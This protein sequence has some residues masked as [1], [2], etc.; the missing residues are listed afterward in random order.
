MKYEQPHDARTESAQKRRVSVSRFI[1]P[2]AVSLMPTMS[3]IVDAAVS[4]HS[5]KMIPTKFSDVK[6]FRT[7]LALAPKAP[8]MNSAVF[9]QALPGHQNAFIGL[10]GMR[11]AFFVRP[12]G[13]DSS[14]KGMK[15]EINL[16]MD[17]T[18]PDAAAF[19]KA[20]EALD[21]FVL[22]EVFARKT[23]LMPSKAA[24][25]T[26]VDALKPMYVSGQFLKPATHAQNGT[27]YPPS[28][29]LK[30]VGN[31]D[32][33]VTSVTTRTVTMRGATRSIPDK[34]TW[35]PRTD[36]VGPEETK[37]F[38]Y[39]RTKE[40]GEDVYVEKVPSADGGGRYVGPE[41]ATPGCFISAIFSLNCVYF[42][43]GFGVSAVARAIY[44]KPRPDALPTFRGAV[45][46]ALATL[47]GTSVEDNDDAA[48]T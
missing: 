8:G 16:Q 25:I 18:S 17:E 22:H 44:I 42:S 27:R 2:D 34:C 39:K 7:V 32:K 23:E 6:D 36:A 45:S 30:V 33:Q 1:N 24:Y 14:K 43:D 11:Q 47:P 15:F 35:A 26:S 13:T 37:F 5:H 46:T 3:K 12:N 38:M 10:P 31:W 19:I 40:N 21:D 28:I 41:D 4:N 48:M 20:C 29:K 9:F